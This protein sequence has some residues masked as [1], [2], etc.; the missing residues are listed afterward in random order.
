MSN[1]LC[2]IN[3]GMK[4]M[5]AIMVSHSEELERDNSAQVRM[6]NL[7]SPREMLEPHEIRIAL[8]RMT[9]LVA[10]HTPLN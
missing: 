6:S 8:F 1:L 10:Y 5:A 2:Q 9:S 3:R 7:K 4:A